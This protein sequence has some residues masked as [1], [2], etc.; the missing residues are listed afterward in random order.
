[1]LEAL[2]GRQDTLYGVC[3]MA[4]TPLGCALDSTLILEGACEGL[5]RCVFN[6]SDTFLG[7]PCL[8]AEEF[9]EIR[10]QCTNKAKEI[11]TPFIVEEPPKRKAIGEW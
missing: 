8:N 4:N 7:D 5:K 1:M 10:Y 6:V 9:L 3:G 2:Y 11:F